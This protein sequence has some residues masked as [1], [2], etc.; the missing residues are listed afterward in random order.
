[1]GDFTNRI[2]ELLER[3]EAASRGA[4]QQLLSALRQAIAR[5]NQI[6]NEELAKLLEHVRDAS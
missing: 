3:L 6:R 1:M 4:E 5:Y 2:I